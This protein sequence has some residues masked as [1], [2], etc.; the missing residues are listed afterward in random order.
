MQRITAKDSVEEVLARLGVGKNESLR[1]SEKRRSNL[2]KFAKLCSR[3][4]D[5]TLDI[6]ETATAFVEVEQGKTQEFQNITVTSKKFSQI[7]SDLPDKYHSYLLQKAQTGHEVGHVLYSSWPALEDF[8]EKVRE[9]EDVDTEQYVT[10]FRDFVNV[11]EDGAIEKFLKE[12]FRIGEELYHLRH[13]LHEQTYMGSRSSNG[14][15]T[16]YFY[17]FFFAIMTACLNIGVYDNEELDKL[18]DKDNDRHSWPPGSRGGGG[19]R[20]RFVNKCLPKIKKYIPKIQS[21]TDARKRT[22]L[23]YKL[24]KFLVPYIDRAPTDSKNKWESEKSNEDGDSYF[25]KTPNNLSEAHGEQSGEPTFIH[26]PSGGEAGL[27]EERKKIAEKGDITVEIENTAKRGIV[28]ESKEQG[29][30]DWSNEIEE[31]INALSAGKGVKELAIAEDEEIDTKRRMAARRLGK[32]CEKVFRKR[33]KES[34]RDTTIRGQRRGD[35]DRRSLVKAQRGSP[36]IFQQTKE[37]D[38]KNY[39]CIIVADRSGSMSGTMSN[40]ELAAGAVAWGLQENGV[41]TSILD[42]HNSKTTLAKPFGTKV[43]SF[44]EKLF[45]NRLGGGTPITGTIQ[46]MRERIDRGE[47]DYPFAIV[48]TDGGAKNKDA[49][50]EEVK[51]A[52]FPV[53]GLYITNDRDEV[54]DQLKRYN[55][56]ISIESDDDISQALINL[57]NS[58]VL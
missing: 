34:K 41:D 26:G 3:N 14:E 54:K 43:E 12:E 49:F 22:H 57:I 38:E 53:L 45:A 44:E 4:P 58:V 2:E 52:N 31:I 35:L 1:E 15:E 46:F 33:L 30:N 25:P 56:A 51:K 39:S 17:P 42:T 13:T 8:T 29:E 10:M 50:K 36:R 20:K 55:R 5:V 28:S 37:S 40:V 6:K 16:I 47:N 21:E 7:D 18:M 24:W 23:C 9:E 48:I 27:G 32:R 11:L 19:D